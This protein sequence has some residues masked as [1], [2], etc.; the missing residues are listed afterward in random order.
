MV[1]AASRPGLDRLG[2]HGQPARPRRSSRRRAPSSIAA[3]VDVEADHLGA[4]ASAN[5]TA[6]GQPDVPETDDSDAGAFLTSRSRAI[7]SKGPPAAPSLAEPLEAA[8]IA[9]PAPPPP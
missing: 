7:E 6:S 3:R 4:L 1:V 5:A 9:A 8:T 2:E